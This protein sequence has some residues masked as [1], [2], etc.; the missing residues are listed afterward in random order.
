LASEH[1]PRLILPPPQRLWSSQLLLVLLCATS[2]FSQEQTAKQE[3]PAATAAAASTTSPV[4][5][6][7]FPEK[8]P[9][10]PFVASLIPRNSRIYIAPFL[11][12]DSEKPV[13][14][15]ATYIAA[16]LRKKNVSLIVVNDR[17]QADFE[18]QGSAD[19]KG[20]GFAKKW[21]LMDFRRTTSASLTV[22]NLRTGVVSYADASHRASANKGLRSS[23]E[24]LAKYLKKK[25]EDDEKKL[26]KQGH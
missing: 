21:L 14:G 20:A 6:P 12:E 16:A 19:M 25:M 9:A 3:T 13:Q 10:D 5:A 1:S 26:A 7:V 23:A 8:A 18:I 24:K 17:S 22:T 15:F 11:S 4:A 2:A